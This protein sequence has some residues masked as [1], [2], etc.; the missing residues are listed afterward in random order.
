[1]TGTAIAQAILIAITP[2]LTRLY[3]PE[4]FGLFALYFS[5]VSVVS[6]ISSGK[7]EK[8]VMLAENDE[9]ALDIIKLC[10][11]LVGVIAFSSFLVFL[12]FGD[13][14]IYKMGGANI[15]SWF[16]FIPITILASSFYNIINLWFVRKKEY[17]NLSSN[18]VIKSAVTGTSNIGLGMMGFGSF[19]L[20]FSEAFSQ[21]LAT[22]F[23]GKKLW[24]ENKT[25]LKIF[26][27]QKIKYIAN[28]FSNFPKFSLPAD[29]IN[30]FSSQLPIF[31]FNSFFAASAVGFYSLTKRVLD[32]PMGLLSSA[33]LEVFS[34]KATEDYQKLGN[35]KEIYIKTF[36]RLLALSFIPFMIFFFAAP[37]IFEIAFGLAWREAGEFARILSVMYFIKFIASPLSFTFYI[38]GKQKEDFLLHI[39]IGISTFLSLF[40]GYY[41][42][43]TMY[44]SLV[45][46]T[47][48]SCFVYLIYLIRS[49]H[50]SYKK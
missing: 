37:Y 47:I 28:K 48:N 6:T 38:A 1:M 15:R 49:Y 11:L 7:Y 29:F 17:K 5:V 33:L 30:I 13:W 27:I 43:K 35:C 20:V 3:S 19:G 4:D 10:L 39:Y 34:Q 24:S 46:F 45:V 21:S 44:A 36:K 42:L 32:A 25:Y 16:Y 26:D 12:V 2:I 40:L 50:H 8:A 14:I 22:I 31:L 23:F 18:R 9:E 41:F